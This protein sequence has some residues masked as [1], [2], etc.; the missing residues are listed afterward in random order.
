MHFAVMGLDRAER[1]RT[2]TAVLKLTP[3]GRLLAVGVQVL[4]EVNQ[5]LTAAK[6]NQE[7]LGGIGNPET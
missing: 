7:G 1:P 4:P 3:V 2:E 6:R 5:I